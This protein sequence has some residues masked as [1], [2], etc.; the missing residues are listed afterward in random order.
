M[1]ISWEDNVE[2]SKEEIRLFLE[3][4]GHD[5]RFFRREMTDTTNGKSYLIVDFSSL[6][7]KGLLCIE[8]DHKWGDDVVE[9]TCKGHYLYKALEKMRTENKEIQEIFASIS[10]EE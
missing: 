4:Y 8:K 10:N 9:F 6:Q 3:V 5:I 1:N 7:K 2:V